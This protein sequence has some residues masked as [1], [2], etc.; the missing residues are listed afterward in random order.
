MEQRV[1]ELLSALPATW[2]DIKL[3]DF[4]KIDTENIVE[5]HE[6]GNEFAY[7]D[8]AIKIVSQLTGAT[9]DELESLPFVQLGKLTN[10]VSFLYKVPEINLKSKFEWKNVEEMSYGDLNVYLQL[11]QKP[12]EYMQ[13][14]IRAFSK[15]ELSEEQ[16]LEMSMYDIHS[17]F[18]FAKGSVTE[19]VS[20]YP[21]FFPPQD[22]KDEVDE[23]REDTTFRDFMQGNAKQILKD[24]NFHF[25]A[26]LV[27]DWTSIDVFSVYDKKAVEVL[28]MHQIMQAY[29]EYNKASQTN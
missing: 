13:L 19:V 14:I 24:Y 9:I 6:L 17:A 25:T 15:K 28:S 8:N 3:K 10:K 11:Y 23:G 4:M 20:R 16:V 5:E 7:A 1:N 22:K 21:S 26:K 18:F 2:S 12:K 27:A 29:A